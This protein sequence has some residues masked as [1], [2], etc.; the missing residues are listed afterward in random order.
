[1]A[2]SSYIPAVTALSHPPGVLLL[3]FTPGVL[4]ISLTPWVSSSQTFESLGEFG[5]AFEWYGRR[6]RM[7][8]GTSLVN[9]W[10]RVVKGWI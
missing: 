1:M 10:T 3:V 5:K 6:C 9:L 2:A 7:V 4:I 8:A